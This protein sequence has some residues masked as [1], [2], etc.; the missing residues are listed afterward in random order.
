MEMFGGM[1]GVR[2]QHF[3]IHSM[4]HEHIVVRLDVA[5]LNSFC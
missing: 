5:L 4:V 2:S 3:T 1:E